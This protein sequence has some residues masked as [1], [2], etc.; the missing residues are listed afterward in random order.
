[1]KLL[2]NRALDTVVRSPVPG[3]V[4]MSSVSMHGAS[5]GGSPC[6]ARPKPPLTKQRGGGTEPNSA[7][8]IGH[9]IPH[10]LRHT[11]A[12]LAILNGTGLEKVQQL[13]GHTNTNTTL[14]YIRALDTVDQLTDLFAR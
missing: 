6:R 4:V 10:I 5:Q 1:M 3:L 7:R 12:T 2:A 13:L 11:A 9:V 14:R 8:D